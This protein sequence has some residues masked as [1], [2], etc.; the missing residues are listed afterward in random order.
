M[1]HRVYVTSLDGLLID[2]MC[3]YCVIGFSA[4]L[5]IH[6]WPEALKR[7]RGAWLACVIV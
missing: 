2:A 1:G 6:G 5:C 4:C 7:S 3:V